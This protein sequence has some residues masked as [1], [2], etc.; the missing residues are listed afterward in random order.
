VI[1]DIAV[2]GILGILFTGLLVA[3]LTISSAEK[4]NPFVALKRLFFGPLGPR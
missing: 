2:Y 3:V 4:V 1:V